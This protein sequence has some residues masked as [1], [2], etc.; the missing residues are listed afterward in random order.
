LKKNGF[1]KKQRIFL[2][3]GF[4]FFEKKRDCV[5]FFRKKHKNPYSE[6]ILLHHVISPFS[7]LHNNNFLYL[8]G[9]SN[10]WVK[11]CTHLC[12]RKVLLVSSLQ[13]GKVGKHAHSR[14]K[15]P[16]PKQTLSFHVKFM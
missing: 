12:F 2:I 9:H 1:K 11:K 5:L 13:S 8:L 10:L 14:Q 16:A 6:L 4:V 7:E 3:R 15:K